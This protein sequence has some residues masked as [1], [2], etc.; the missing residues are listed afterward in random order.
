MSRAKAELPVCIHSLV[1]MALIRI[2]GRW[3]ALI[4]LRLVEREHRFAELRQ[5]LN[6]ISEKMLTQQLA[7][8]ERDG[9]LIRTEIESRPPKVVSY[10]LSSLGHQARP[11][12]DALQEFG[13]TLHRNTNLEASVHS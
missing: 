3:K 11:V 12:L 1:V 6:G 5:A 9:L 4:L 2:N 7:E 13:A 8:L 10:S